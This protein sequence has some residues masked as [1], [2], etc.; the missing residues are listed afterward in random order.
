MNTD[1]NDWAPVI[2]QLARFVALPE[3]W[4]VFISWAGSALGSPLAADQAA[5]ARRDVDQ[6]RAVASIL[7][8]IQMMPLERHDG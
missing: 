3:T 2:E 6:L 4:P 1:L 5:K 8:E 7:T